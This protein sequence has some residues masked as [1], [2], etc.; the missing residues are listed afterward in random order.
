MNTGSI[1]KSRNICN[2]EIGSEGR[3]LTWLPVKKKTKASLDSFIPNNDGRTS[4][5][6]A[7]DINRKFHCGSLRRRGMTDMRNTNER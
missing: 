7:R 2:T 1:L 5:L 3:K 6:L 4:S